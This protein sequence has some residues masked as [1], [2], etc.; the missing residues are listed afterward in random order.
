M[1]TC[2]P[3][4]W[5]RK[6]RT[7]NIAEWCDVRVT[8]TLITKMQRDVQDHGRHVVI[9]YSSKG[10]CYSLFQQ[11]MLLFPILAR[12]VVIPYSSKGC[13]YSLF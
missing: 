11:G 8:D 9:P 10:C 7:G 1:H 13:C 4:M 3:E 12:D 2:K 6:T 5:P